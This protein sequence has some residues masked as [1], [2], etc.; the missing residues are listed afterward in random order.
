MA[1]NFDPTSRYPGVRFRALNQGDL[2]ADFSLGINIPV[3]EI[4]LGQPKLISLLGEQLFRPVPSAWN[5][6]YR[7]YFLERFAKADARRGF[8]AQIQA[9]DFRIDTVPFKLQRYTWQTLFDIDELGI[10]TETEQAL[11]VPLGVQ[12]KAATLARDIVDLSVEYD[13]A[14]VVL[15]SASY[16]T[17]LDVTLAGGSQWDNASAGDSRTSIRSMAAKIAAANALQI[18][19]IDVYLTFKALEAAQN[20]PLFIQRRQ[21]AIGVDVPMEEQIRQYWGVGRI[22]VG[23]AFFSSDN[24]T[25][26]SMYTD[27]LGVYN[28]IAV[29]RV[30]QALQGYDTREG[31]L[32]SFV[33]FNWR[34]AQGALMPYMIEER[35]SWAFPYQWHEFQTQVNKS[36]AG[37]IRNVH[38]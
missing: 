11:G 24:T 12:A 35:T 23:D 26:Q 22:I 30:S 18:P 7:K 19:N 27:P 14:T 2:A 13:R 28:S 20:D 9:S 32:D 21:Y 5:G 4:I 6:M 10:A 31:Q 17:G 3:N 8:R 38:S 33:R 15:A 37:I 1:P 29:L 36:A 16:G 25:L 34:G